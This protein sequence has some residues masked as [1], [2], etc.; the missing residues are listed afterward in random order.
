MPHTT[1]SRTLIVIVGPTAVGKTAACITLAQKLHADIVSADSRQFYQRMNIGTAKP[2]AEERAAAPHHFIDFLPLEESYNAGRYAQEALVLLE[3]LWERSPYVILTGGS[4]LYIDALCNGLPEMPVVPASITQELEEAYAA[5]GLEPLVKELASKD[6]VYYQQVD[7]HNAK[8]IIRALGVCRATGQRFSLFRAQKIAPRNFQIIKIGLTRPREELY[9]RINQ[10]V[11]A[12]VSEGLFQEIEALYPYR[13]L[14]SL[15]TIA[16][17]EGFGY[18]EGRYDK[19][20]AIELIKQ[21]TRQY[22]KRQLTWFKKDP[23]IH[24]FAP[25]QIGRCHNHL[26]RIASPRP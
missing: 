5:D 26:T 18:M 21:H 22:A 25:D 20:R 2:T 17:Q 15:A 11:D 7:R 10:R 16:Y 9:A 8:R 12:M 1:P 24:W 14:P 19:A 6:P 13:K 3:K 4:G 23:T